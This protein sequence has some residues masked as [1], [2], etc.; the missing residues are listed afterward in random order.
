MLI[1]LVLMLIDFGG[2]LTTKFVFMNNQ[3]HMVRLMLIDL[4]SDEFY[5]YPCIIILKKYNRSYST[6]EAP[7][8]R[9]CVPNKIEDV[10]LKM[11]N[12]I[13]GKTV[14][15]YISSECRSKF[16]GRNCN[17]IQIRNNDKCQCKCK[18][19][20]IAH[21]KKIRPGILVYAPRSGIKIVKLV[22]T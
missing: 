20:G 16:N 17:S 10:N 18:K 2:S 9:I 19:L 13:K 8:G 3:L 6:L 7:F 4:N 12:R 15:K 14:A 11:F 22:N 21:V 1:V 5:Y